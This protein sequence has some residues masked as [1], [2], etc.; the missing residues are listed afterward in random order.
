MEDYHV[1]Y[2]FGGFLGPNGSWDPNSHLDWKY[3]GF[4]FFTLNYEYI[5]FSN[6]RYNEGRGEKFTRPKTDSENLK[7]RCPVFR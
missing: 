2:F 6:S 5:Y 7:Y 3:V 4:C 1:L